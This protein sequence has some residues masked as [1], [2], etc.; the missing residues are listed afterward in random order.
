M[1]EDG[2]S[3]GEIIVAQTSALTALCHG[4]KILRIQ[5]GSTFLRDE[6]LE[7]LQLI[8]HETLCATGAVREAKTGADE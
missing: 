6:T 7:S 3:L 5:L 1:S 8:A 4:I 2:R